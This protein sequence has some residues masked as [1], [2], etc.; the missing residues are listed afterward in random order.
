MAIFAVAAAAADNAE[1]SLKLISSEIHVTPGPQDTGLAELMVQAQGF[2]RNALSRGAPRAEDLGI[3]AVPAIGIS[4]ADAPREISRSDSGVIWLYRLT[5]AGLPKRTSSARKM[6]LVLGGR[7]FTVDYTLTDKEPGTFAWSILAPPVWNF[8]GSPVAEIPIIVKDVP[9]SGIRILQSTL[10][11]Q[12]TPAVV[13]GTGDI[14]LCVNRSGKCSEPEIIGPNDSRTLYLRM[15]SVGNGSYTGNLVIRCDQKPE[16]DT[17]ALTVNVTGAGAQWEGVGL[18]ALGV[19][20]YFLA[21]VYARWRLSTN[22]RRELALLLLEQVEQ[23]ESHANVTVQGAPE[24]AKQK[25]TAAFADWK[26]K[27]S[28]ASLNPVMPSLLAP[29]AKADEFKAYL[30]KEGQRLESVK[31]VMDF[32]MSKIAQYWL[33]AGADTAKQA[34]VQGAVDAL[35]AIPDG[36]ITAADTKTKVDSLLGALETKLGIARPAG[37]PAG[38]DTQMQLQH[39]WLSSREWTWL[40][41]GV[42]FVATVLTGAMVMVIGKAGFGAPMDFGLCLLWGLGFPAAGSQL[43]SM[44]APNIGSSLGITLPK[45]T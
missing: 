31:A 27:L 11:R 33:V 5:V 6:L 41:F 8:V 3:P 44:T 29:D 10:T 35:L 24:R 20:L 40:V 9:A 26:G 13:V 42:W 39:V 34:A 1:P 28:P 45:A 37:L 25:T 4:I 19:V 21:S 2:P 12:S 38:A 32:G 43:N 36:A 30:Q 18:L 17:V 7:Q 15:E 14:E 22:S 23:V 16:G